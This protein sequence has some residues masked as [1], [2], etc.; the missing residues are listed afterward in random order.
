VAI[1]PAINPG[2]AVAERPATLTGAMNFISGGS[3]LGSSVVASAAN[4]IVGFQR[5]AAAVTPKAPDLGSIINT[6]STNILSNVENRL[7]S[8]NQN[9]QQI[10]QNNFRSQLDEYRNKVKEVTE[11]PPSKIL[12]N[13]LSL[14]KEAIGYVQ[15][16]GDR[17]NI[18]RLGDNL[19]ALQNVFSETFEIAA[20]VRNTIVKIVKQLSNLPTASGGPG[21][22]NLDINIPGG[23]LKK[24]APGKSKLIQMIGMGTAAA[25]AGTLGSKV[26]SGMLDVGGEVQPDT[27]GTISAIPTP[28]LDRFI[29]VLNRFDK[30]LQGFQAPQK[31]QTAP[32]APSAP[33]KP[34]AGGGGGEGGGGS[35]GVNAAD[36]SADTAEEKAFI[37]T[38]R[39]AEGTGGAQGYNT[40]YGGAVVPQLT[41]MTLKEL[42]DASKVG[43]T[44]RLPQRLG[45]GII[46]YKK[47]QYNSSASGAAQL[48]PGTLKSLVDSG[49]FSWDQKFSPELQNQ[50]ILYL[51]KRRGIDVSKELTAADFKVLG[52][53]WAGLSEY[54]GQGGS[55][56]R[57]GKLYQE[58]LKEARGKVKATG[59]PEE[60]AIK[61]ESQ[62][63]A[64]TDRSQ[65]IKG[66]A[67]EVSRPAI[68]SD[69]QSNVSI[70]PLVMGSP[71]SNS[72][73]SGSQMS[74][75]P[76]MSK[77]GATIPFLSSSNDDNFFTILSKV[78]YNIVDG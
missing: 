47:D 38:V 77:G 71:Q 19:Q 10:V 62:I 56:G 5:G 3:T 35:K 28:I 70:V 29:E 75:P 54:H 1:K 67:G 73:P 34:D 6:L 58:N 55:L 32:S 40:V 36:I 25:G 8:V 18:R 41:E 27:S 51:A 33:Q 2:V 44:N 72:T 13:F 61:L 78:V 4:K 21:G 30:A 69:K 43:G 46:P 50:I 53:E 42:Y 7:Q 76:V 9:I 37:S 48:M 52:R 14:Y 11:N 59:G 16:L 60:D 66:I 15:F 64:S 23:P 63:R 24:A 26:V 65:T 74:L 31:K 20:L 68:P 17:R 45:G 57:T 39:E 49:T 22:L 12:Q